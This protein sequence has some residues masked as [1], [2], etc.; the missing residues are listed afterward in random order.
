MN[1]LIRIIL[2]ALMEETNLGDT[3]GGRQQ[4]LEYA[5]VAAEA[6]VRYGWPRKEGEES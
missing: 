1:E 6:I 3:Q 2:E 4:A 5:Q